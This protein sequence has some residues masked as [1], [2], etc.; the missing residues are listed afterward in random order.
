IL[1]HLWSRRRY[2]P[3]PWAAMAF[4]L[5][6]QRK[7]ARRIQLEQWLLLAVRTAILV[8]FALALAD[9]QLSVLSAWA[10][11]PRGQTHVVRVMYGSYS[12]DYRREDKSRFEAAKEVAKQIVQAGRQGDGYTLVLMGQ[13]PR[14]VIGR[15][16]FDRADVLQEIDNLQ[17]AHAGANLPATLGEV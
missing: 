6:A 1:I 11:G 17:F 14:V 8:L 9:P 5:A 7:N 13:P 2:R 3:E 12:R 16:A 10:S 4:L 15:P